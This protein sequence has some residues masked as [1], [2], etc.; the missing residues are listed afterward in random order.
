MNKLIIIIFALLIS[1]KSPS[2]DGKVSTTNLAELQISFSSKNEKEF[3]KNFPKDFSSFQ[4]IF[5]WNDEKDIPE[6][7]NNEANSYIDYW[8]FLI[9]KPAY[10]NYEPQ[11]I[12]ISKNG[13][14]EADAVNYFSQKSI[15][16][17]KENNRYNLINSLSNQEAQSVLSF[18]FAHSQ[19]DSLF[20]SKL[21]LDKREILNNILSKNN[22]SKK[23]RS[24]LS[25]YE[26][27]T[28]YFIKNFDVNN[29][30]I[31][32]KIVS[33]KPY[34]G[35][36][37]F[38]FLGNKQGDY[39][40]VLET[41]NFSEDGGN[42]IQDILP[43]TGNSGL[44]VKTHFPDRGFYEKEYY[45]I[46]KNNSWF[47]R[48]IVYKTMSDVSENAIKYIC[49]V[50]QNIDITKSGW[51][52]KINPIPGE[53]ERDE[54]CWIENA[55]EDRTQ[56]FIWDKDG[57]TNLRKDKN[58]SSEILK[59]LNSGEE[60]EVLNNS[61]DWW[62]IKTKEGRTGYIHKSRIKRN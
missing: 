20:I 39:T 9:E 62:L 29:D 56:F 40:L 28:D 46:F 10:K 59:K 35:E 48:N 25:T 34:Q 23:K 16:Y 49:D 54:K 13:F 8:F 7:L 26:N 60:I 38:I 45:L 15:S 41:T 2:Q 57:Y 22:S 47:L 3:L 51:T 37:L 19:N 11:I 17:I 53:N 24:T 52:S 36:D 58:T 31:Q 50:P 4:K 61:G 12:S 6:P 18:L 27:N 30:K 44:E 21:N 5:G 43:I 42:I 14:W 33:S 55:N 32:D 1:C